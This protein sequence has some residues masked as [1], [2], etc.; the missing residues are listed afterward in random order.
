MNFDNLPSALCC[1]LVCRDFVVFEDRTRQ[2]THRLRNPRIWER[3][4]IRRA[5]PRG[6]SGF[7]TGLYHTADKCRP[8]S[9]VPTARG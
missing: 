7:Q 1:C 5:F 8:F 6:V 3:D 2:G 4:A 9:L